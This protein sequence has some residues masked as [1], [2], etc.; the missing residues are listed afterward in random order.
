MIRREFG[1]G[2]G[3]DRE[4]DAGLD[5]CRSDAGQRV[6]AARPEDGLDLDATPDGHVGPHPVAFAVDSQTLTGTDGVTVAVDGHDERPDR[7]DDQ[8]AVRLDRRRPRIVADEPI[9]EVVGGAVDST[10]A[11]DAQIG[12][13]D[14]AVVLQGRC[15]ARLDDPQRRPAHGSA[16]RK[17]TKRPGLSTAG[18]SAP[19]SQSVA[20]VVGV[21][22]PMRCQ[23][24]GDSAG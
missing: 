20:V 1:A 2:I 13:T 14:P 24:P 22:V 8:A 6:V 17:R 11:G 23:P 12:P 5:R 18:G 10:C 15:A 19:V 3:S 21:V 16:C 7:F 9:G 4:C